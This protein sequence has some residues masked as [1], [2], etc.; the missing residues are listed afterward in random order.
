MELLAPAGN[1]ECLMAAVNSGADAVYFAGKSFGA[2]S[3]ADN[4]SYQE[5]GEAISY[6]HL[7][8]VK[9]YITVNTMTLDREFDELDEFIKAL[10]DQGA[11]GVIV[12]DLGVAERIRRICPSL[13]VHGST[14]MTVH[15]LEGVLALKKMGI[16]RVVL[17]R[18]LSKDDIEYITQNCGI[19][20]EV[21][22][23]GAMCMSYSGQCLMSSVLGG[24]SGNRGKCA[25][26]CRLKYHSGDNNEGCYLSLKDMSLIS[27]LDELS[28]MGVASL[29]IEGR[30]KGAEYVSAVVGTYRRCIDENRKPTQKE[31]ENMNSVFFRGGLTD[32]YFT[33]KKG[34]EMFAFDKPD[35][36]YKKGENIQKQEIPEKKTKAVCSVFL[37]EGEKARLEISAMGETAEVYGEKPLEK[38]QKN[39]PNK[40]DIKSRISKTGGTAFEM[41]DIKVEIG[42]CPFVSASEL[43][44][45]RR[46][47]ID[48][49]SEKILNK[50]KKTTEVV[51][52][53][54]HKAY[55]RNPLK[56]TATVYTKEQFYAVIQFDFQWIGVPLDLVYENLL[57]F[58]EYK[59]RIVICPPVIVPD[60]LRENIEKQLDKLKEK[61]FDRIV[62]ENIS[63]FNSKAFKIV[64]GHR[65][66]I[67]NSGAVIEYEKLGA[68]SVCLSAELNMA[69]IRDIEKS[70][71]T[72]VLAYG[73]LPLM[74]CENCILK[75]MD[76]C[77]CDGFGYVYDRKGEK[78]PVIKDGNYCRSVVLNTVPLYMADKLDDFEKAGVQLARLMFTIE[79]GEETSKI[80][81][82]YMD[83][84]EYNRE[85]TR[86]HY[87]KNLL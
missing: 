70:I 14:Q 38:A 76:K 73:H 71:A 65:L 2:R 4:F 81:Q 77:S 36:P 26:P 83:R 39:P 51:A 13:P 45:L 28:K 16:T 72:E 32:G 56:Y 17:S 68:E 23:H 44:G 69:Q 78:F 3:F 42:G 74:V 33:G 61:G 66:N 10:A 40:E 49:L 18:E 54:Q 12:Q 1:M 25:Q 7:R 35:N 6:C 15:N 84:K 41:I 86:L 82:W 37:K 27:H 30:M 53:K 52:K 59:K 80:C 9:A 48:A 29:K 22:V 79:D 46:A 67:A 19:E 8:G 47:G 57:E 11:D 24:R 5:L 31:I 75:N 58:E 87:Y 34:K 85:F 63:W 62:A 60:S 43:N 55:N 21:F 20:I 50:Y 64:G